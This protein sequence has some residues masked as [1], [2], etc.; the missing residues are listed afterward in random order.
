MVKPLCLSGKM[1]ATFAEGA[2]EDRLLELVA[3][4]GP[5]PHAKL[6]NRKVKKQTTRMLKVL[7]GGCG[8][9]CRTTQKWL[10]EVGTPTC[11]C[12]TEMEGPK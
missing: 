3:P 11:A 10:D 5:Y 2:L 12:G 7:C 9:T 4:L 1:T 6:S 8:F